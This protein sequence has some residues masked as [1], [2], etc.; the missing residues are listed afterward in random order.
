M[1]SLIDYYSFTVPTERDFDN[2]MFHSNRTFVIDLFTTYFSDITL[3]HFF[4][5]NWEDEHGSGF[6]KSRIRHA[7]TDVCIS[8]GG[9][10]KHIFVELAGKACASLD[11]RD[12]LI[13]LIT[14]THARAS[15]IDFAFDIECDVSPAEFVA[16][17]NG[18]AF[19]SNGSINSESGSTVYV[20]SRKAD[21]MARVYRY[22]PPHPRAAYL[23]VEAEYKGDAAK[24][25]SAVVVRDGALRSCLAAHLPFGWGHSVFDTTDTTVSRVT[26]PYS[27]P[28]DAST[29]RWLYGD[30][31]KA[32]ARC[33]KEGLIDFDDWL[34]TVKECLKDKI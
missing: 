29:V 25:F 17:R 8:Y 31:P 15:R 7:D 32:V 13:P 33:V 5:L 30:I 11:A 21:R 14:N 19:K 12:L 27:R 9:V 34:E 20:G 4:T 6:Y 24:A 1:I 26:I 23:R 22:Y 2:Q 18:K 3:Q 16:F 10:N 28:K